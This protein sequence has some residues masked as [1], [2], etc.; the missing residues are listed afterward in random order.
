MIKTPLAL[1]VSIVDR[2]ND[3]GILRILKDHD[4]K[5]Y[6]CCLGCGTAHSEIMDYLGLD[7]P[8]KDIILCVVDSSKTQEIMNDI[9]E[10][11]QLNR[12]GAGIMFT[13]PT[14][15]INADASEYIKISNNAQG[16]EKNMNNE[17]EY[18][19]IV[20]IVSRG[21]SDL[22]MK[23]AVAA[24]ANGGT[25][26]R[27]RGIGPDD[28]DGMKKLFFQPEKEVVLL[29]VTQESAKGIMEAICN[30]VTDE[31]N[32]RVVTFALP[33][34]STLGIYKGEPTEK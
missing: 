27:S 18:K 24:G 26:M 34:D 9:N 10:R 11:M 28:A 22:V 15:A 31:A 32:E 8:E 3:K 6:W 23:A 19:L 17:M 14:S 16:E 7:E 30:R 21:L 4:V 33:I 2:G 13:V 1:L 25:I 29:V 20:N 5:L 12:R